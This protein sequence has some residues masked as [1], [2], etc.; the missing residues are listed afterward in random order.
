MLMMM[1]M[2]SRTFTSRPID[3]TVAARASTASLLLLSYRETR[4]SRRCVERV[5]GQRA[6]GNRGPS[7]S[8]ASVRRSR[9]VPSIAQLVERWTVERGEPS[10]NSPCFER[11]R[12]R[13]FTLKQSDVPGQFFL[14]YYTDRNCRKLKGTIDL[15]QC[16]QVDAGLRLDRQKE[17]YAH[18]FDVKTPT[19]TYYLAAE[20]EDDMRGWVNC[21]CQVCNLQETQSVDDRPYYNIGAI[22]MNE[23][24]NMA[25]E[26]RAPGKTNTGGPVASTTETDVSN[27]TET[28]ILNH[29]MVVAGG[30]GDQQQQQQQGRGYSN[31]P[32]GTYQNEEMM[33]L[34]STAGNGEYSN[35]ETIICEA[36]LHTQQQQQQQQHAAAEA[37]SNLD[38]IIERSQSLRGK[39]NGHAGAA[40]M[41]AAGSAGA[42]HGATG[43]STLVNHMRTQSLNIEQ[44]STRKIPEN[45]KLTDRSPSTSAFDSGPDQPSPALSTSSGPYIPISECYSGSPVTPLNSLDPR[46]YETPRSHANVGFNLNVSNEQPYSPKR[47]NVGQQQ[48]GVGPS[49][50]AT[51]RPAGGVVPGSG[52]SSPSDSE[53][54]FTDD[55]WTAP[56]ANGGGTAVGTREAGSGVM[57]RGASNGVATIDRNTR[58]SDSSIENDAVGWTYVQRFSKVPNAAEDKQHQQHQQP[59]TKGATGGGNG[60]TIKAAASAPPRP[61]KRA[62]M[63]LDGIENKDFISSDT[64]NVSPA[65]I[66]PNDASSCIEE[67]YD[68]PR[69]HQH[70]YTGSSMHLD[71]DLL[72]PLS[73][74]DLVASSTPNLI[75][76]FGGSVCGTLGRNPRPHCYTN[77]APT[78]VEGNVF[79]FDFSE[80]PDAP[81]INRRLK[82]RGCSSMDITKSIESITQGVKQLGASS[83]GNS[84]PPATPGAT[85][86]PQA[87][88]PMAK[89]PPTIDRTRKPATPNIGSLRR[90]GG[91]VVALNLAS[92]QSTES[93]YGNTTQHDAGVISPQVQLVSISPRAPPAGK[94]EDRL[95][96]LDLD[97]SNSPQKPH[98]NGS[99]NGTGPG[100]MLTHGNDTK[101]PVSG[102]LSDA[103]S[104]GGSAHNHATG[105]GP[106]SSAVG[107]GSTRSLEIPKAPAPLLTNRTPY[108]TVDFVKTDAF[109]RIRADSELTRSQ[110]PRQKDPST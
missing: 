105:G 38:V 86:Q 100:G 102:K 50:L 33:G 22:N 52:K 53:S 64:E 2:V 59:Q 7:L 93:T 80:Q 89:S 109:N 39:P 19:R 92:S 96:Y 60:A 10:I 51:V 4:H 88:V 79:R 26:T 5:S 16:E 78:K 54:V 20:T 24:V 73:H 44:R 87:V 110:Q 1:M 65:I 58:P 63:N 104:G 3:F 6:N 101:Q 69:S 91:P 31:N 32:Y 43:T 81:A 75:S 11:W 83:Q 21:I 76:E 62:S 13:W 57:I 99:N 106:G 82:P 36:K 25:V 74:C 35:R 85:G 46:F 18:M 71:G 108:T 15:D 27:E 67:F 12:R 40:A 72:S 84:V 47:S 97:H 95:Q 28:T 107:G 37:Y 23:A 70:P 77:A 17:K 98:G 61:P 41:A 29:S 66:G 45:L 34:R 103:G 30:V 42:S 8:V 94:N 48:T 49:S 9:H 56:V 55:E 90:K 14:E 68:I